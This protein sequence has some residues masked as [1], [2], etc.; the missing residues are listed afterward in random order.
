M[1]IYATLTA[2]LMDHR[3][4]DLWS[5]FALLVIACAVVSACWPSLLVATQS[6]EAINAVNQ[7]RF[8][9]VFRRLDSID[10]LLRG[11][12]LL[13][14][15]TLTALVVQIWNQRRGRIRRP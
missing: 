1:A 11:M 14:L 2:D 6:Q 12:F 3:R 7:E 4:S 8:G 13:L 15:S 9:E 5:V 10:T